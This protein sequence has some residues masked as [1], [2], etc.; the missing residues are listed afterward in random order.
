[1]SKVEKEKHLTEREIDVLICMRKGY[2]N[3]KISNILCI[4]IHTV[5]AHA[6]SIYEKINAKN[7]VEL[8][9]MIVGD[10]EIHAPVI[11]AQIKKINWD[12]Y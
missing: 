9:L 1:M 8:L 3:P 4:T 10:M 12:K 2:S 7:R 11:K 6:S 5:K